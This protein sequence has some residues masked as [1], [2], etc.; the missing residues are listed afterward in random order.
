MSSP[1][2]ATNYAKISMELGGIAEYDFV[3]H[4][5]ARAVRELKTQLSIMRADGHGRKEF[6]SSPPELKPGLHVGCGS[7]ILPDYTNLD[8]FPNEGVDVVCDAREGLPFDSNQFETVFS[9]H[10][11]EHVDYPHSVK[12]ILQEMVRVT[13]PGGKVIVGVPDASY[14]IRAYANEDTDFFTELKERWYKNRSNLTHYTQPVDFVR[15]VL[16]DED[17]DPVYTPHLWGYDSQSLGVLLEE[18]GLSD[19]TPWQYDPSMSLEKRQWGS[20]YLQGVKP[21]GE[22]E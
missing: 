15:L 4:G 18:A 6:A 22:L 20:V 12:G 8:I 9:E 3:P 11:L 14:A 16:A 1:E 21:A 7:N 13:K 17:D 19:V 10:M 2:D 5:V